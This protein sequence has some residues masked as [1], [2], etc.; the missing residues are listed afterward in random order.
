MRNIKKEFI[1][2]S[3]FIVFIILLIYWAIALGDGGG[4]GF[5]LGLGSGNAEFQNAMQA[6]QQILQLLTQLVGNLK[7]T[8]ESN[9]QSENTRL[10]QINAPRLP[11]DPSDSQTPEI[12][13]MQADE[14]RVEMNFTGLEITLEDRNTGNKIIV[15]NRA[16][17]VGLINTNKSIENTI[18]ENTTSIF[19][20]NGQ[21]LGV[22][23]VGNRTTLIDT[24][25]AKVDSID[26]S[27]AGNLGFLT[28]VSASE[29]N[30]NANTFLRQYVV[31]VDEDIF[32]NGDEILF[33]PLKDFDTIVLNGSKLILMEM[34]ND[35]VLNN[36][37][38]FY[39]RKLGKNNFV[40]KKIINENNKEMF[41]SLLSG[42]A[43]GVYFV[44]DKKVLTV[45][46][47][48]VKNPVDY[49]ENISIP[50]SRLSMWKRAVD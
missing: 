28:L 8:M 36:D 22:V 11:E 7:A 1:F 27:G 43:D 32:I 18:T 50:V 30:R 16:N 35:V 9:A 21:D 34:D 4:L 29:P 39:S 19:T 20:K 42:G 44:D 2:L 45:G 48:V 5:G 37:K 10:A 26:N 33:F 41:F 14:N 23:Q 47:S 13:D 3:S 49:Y 6:V 25:G 31:F 17:V 12:I 46:D 15:Q 24:G 38:T 40:V